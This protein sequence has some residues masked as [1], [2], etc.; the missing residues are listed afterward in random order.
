MVISGIVLIMVP[1][2]AEVMWL[3]QWVVDIHFQFFQVITRL[4]EWPAGVLVGIILIWKKRRLIPAYL[5]GVLIVLA[6]TY[7]L[8]HYVFMDFDRPI[9]LLPPNSVHFPDWHLVNKQFSF[10]SG[11]TLAAFYFWSFLAMSFP[12]R[13]IHIFSLLIAL[14]VGFSRIVLLQ[15]FL[16][17]V[18]AGSI[19]GIFIAAEI[20]LILQ[21]RNRKNER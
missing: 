12:A 21:I 18:M 10:P 16:I 8:K 13:S 9:K 7:F 14:L 6:L 15:H 17:D 3:N 19:I 11:H 4:G 5:I 2:G 20:H 1:K